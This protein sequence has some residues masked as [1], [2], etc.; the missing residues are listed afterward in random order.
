MRFFIEIALYGS[1]FVENGNIGL[2]MFERFFYKQ[3]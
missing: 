3:I 1:K 2:K